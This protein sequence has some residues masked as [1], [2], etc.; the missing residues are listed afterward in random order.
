MPVIATSTCNALYYQ[1][2]GTG[3]PLVFVHGW[4]FSGVVWQSQRELFQNC[5]RCI[6]VDL[7]GHGESAPSLSGYALDDF[8]T[9]LGELFAHLDL[10]E[11]VLVGWSLGALMALAAA[12]TYRDRI[13]ALVL[14]AGT[15]RFTAT[16]NYSCGLDV[17]EI[18]GLALRL[19]RN[20]LATFE[21]FS[22]RMFTPGDVSAGECSG[23]YVD[24][25][26]GRLPDTNA[27]L[28]SLETLAVSDLRD[29]LPEVQLP[30]LVVHGEGDGICPVVA[31]RFMAERLPEARL[32]LMPGVGH[33]PF[34]SFPLKFARILQDFI[35]RLY[36]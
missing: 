18:R 19:R 10:R 16:D 15:P 2:T 36:G 1:D 23:S 34:L 4:S 20:Q 24:L 14:V 8:V 6:I 7:P 32:A 5:F 28:Q 9:S 30:V 12:Q 33:A 3:N 11:V 22:R 31:A 21:D 35:G 17:K 26:A 25:V 13:S 29:I 27:A